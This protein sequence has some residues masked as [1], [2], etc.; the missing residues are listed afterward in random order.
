MLID[1]ADWSDRTHMYVV[2]VAQVKRGN[3]FRSDLRY[4][5]QNGYSMSFTGRFSKLL[6]DRILGVLDE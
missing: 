2:P 1:T 5:V 3:L 4:E 6:S